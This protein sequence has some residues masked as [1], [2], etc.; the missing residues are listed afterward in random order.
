MKVLFRC[1]LGAFLCL[2]VISFSFAG[3]LVDINSA[4][5]AT[6]SNE[7]KGVGLVKARAIV[8]YRELHGRFSS[9]EELINV[10]GIGELSLNKIRNRLTVSLESEDTP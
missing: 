3:E 9:V 1:L 8:E 2:S 5:I 10:K 4:D 6:L 7:V